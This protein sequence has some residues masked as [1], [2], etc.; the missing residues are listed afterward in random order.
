FFGKGKA[1]VE[2]YNKMVAERKVAEAVVILVITAVENALMEWSSAT[3]DKLK[4]GSPQWAEKKLKTL[5]QSIMATAKRAITQ[6]AEENKDLDDINFAELER[7]A[8]GMN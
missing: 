4:K 2:T 8:E 1:D 6:I 3:W 5:F 7:E